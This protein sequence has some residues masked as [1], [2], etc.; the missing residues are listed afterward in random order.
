MQL[1]DIKHIAVIGSWT[2]GAW[3]SPDICEQGPLGLFGRRE[4]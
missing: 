3:D 4:R 1:E 2:H